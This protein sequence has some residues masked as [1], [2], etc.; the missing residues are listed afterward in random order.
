LVIT[1]TPQLQS[2]SFVKM[3]EILYQRYGF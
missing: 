2:D 3:V 1:G